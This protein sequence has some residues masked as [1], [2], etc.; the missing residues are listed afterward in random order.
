MRICKVLWGGACPT[1]ILSLAARCRS[2]NPIQPCSTVTFCSLQIYQFDLILA[3]RS[4]TPLEN[5]STPQ[6]AL[7]MQS[8]RR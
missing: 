6:I 8:E 2:T 5:G 7:D 3:Y 1:V 4:L